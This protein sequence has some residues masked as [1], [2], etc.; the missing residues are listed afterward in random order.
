MRYRIR[1]LAVTPG[2]SRPSTRSSNVLGLYCSSVCVASTCSTSL[3][4][5][6]K[7]KRPERAVRGRV[8]VAA[9]DRHARLR[10]TQFRADDVDDPLLR[11]VEI[12]QAN[13]E[14]AA[15][16]AQ[17]V[18]LLFG[19]RIGDRQAAIGRGHVVVGRGHGQLRPAHPAAGQP[20]S[21]ERLGAGHFV[22]QVQVDVQDRLLARLRPRRRGRPRSFRTS[23]AEE[24]WA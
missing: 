12:V 19:N 16:V 15:V 13:A 21:L 14:L 2:S 22:D 18:D 1:S 11:I 17:G 6:P 20:Q 5:M 3:V 8:A 24:G 9:D 23:S 10:Q 4:P 7:A